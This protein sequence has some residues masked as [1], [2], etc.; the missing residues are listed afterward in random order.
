MKPR[1]SVLT[2]GVQDLDRSLAFYR[3]GLGFQTP[4]IIGEEFGDG[5][6]AFVDLQRGLRLALWP[7]RSLARDTGLPLEKGGTP[8]ISLGHNVASKEAVD[9]VIEQ[10]GRVGAAIVKEATDTFYGG[11]AGYLQDPDEFL[12][13]IVWNPAFLPAD[14]EGG[15]HE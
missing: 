2:L 1:L 14:G 11:Y 6:V 9:V 3:D 12:W 15:G 7:S 8:R 10:A 5:A 13:E 4:G